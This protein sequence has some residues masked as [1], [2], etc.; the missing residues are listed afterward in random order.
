MEEP[1]DALED[2]TEEPY[3]ESLSESCWSIR[4][5][6]RQSFKGGWVSVTIHLRQF[7]RERGFGD[8]S[9]GL[10]ARW[11]NPSAADFPILLSE[12]AGLFDVVS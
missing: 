6:V 3:A 4:L 9:R 1:S 12:R 11:A 8:C 7:A 5:D 2:A 10:L